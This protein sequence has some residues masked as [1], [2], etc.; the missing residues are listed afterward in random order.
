[1]PLLLATAEGGRQ[2]VNLL[3]YAKHYDSILSGDN[4][5]YNVLS[6]HPNIVLI[7]FMGV[8]KSRIAQNLARRLSLKQIE[9]DDLIVEREGMPI[10]Q[11]FATKGEPYFRDSES[12]VVR[13]LEDER[14]LV[15][16][17]GG[18]VALRPENVR[19]LKKNGTII[20]LTAS[21]QTIFERVRHATHRPILNQD[22]SVDFI[23]SL[24]EGR[25]PYYES[26]ADLQISTDGKSVEEIGEEI[27]HA[28][29]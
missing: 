16:S 1:M 3:N 17:C 13:G 10:E 24:M 23:S 28:L 18:G 12:A 6:D 21:P 2:P 15:I 27:I 14:A 26:A 4:G 29:V 7:G 11:I 5:G 25:L 22:M 8:G 19:S 20:W 9:T